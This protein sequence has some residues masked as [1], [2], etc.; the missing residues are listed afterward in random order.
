MNFKFIYEGICKKIIHS[1]LTVIQFTIG[2]MCIF[3]AIQTLNDMNLSISNI[4]SYFKD[5]EYCN[6]KSES[7]AND[8]YSIKVDDAGLVGDIN[9]LIKIKDY[10]ENSKEFDFLHITIDDMPIKRNSVLDGT[11][12]TYD[13]IEYK[14]EEYLRVQA[15]TANKKF[16]KKMNY[17][18]IKG[19]IEDFESLKTEVPVILGNIYKDK[20]N[21]GDTIGA[22][23]LDGI[24]EEAIKLK[25][26]G[27]LDKDN[28]VFESGISVV[29]QTLDNSMI[30]PYNDEII[31][32]LNGAKT[33][34]KGAI[35][36][37]LANY[38]RYGYMVLNENIDIKKINKELDRFKYKFK[39]ESLEKE[40]KEYRKETMDTLSPVIF[41]AILIIAFTMISIVIIMIN[42]I[43]KDKAEYGINIMLGATMKDIKKRVVG[44]VIILL[45]ISCLISLGLLKAIP[46]F[47][48][49][50]ID[51]MITILIM[52]IFM[53]IV[54][55][56]I[57]RYLNKY[58]VTDLIRRQE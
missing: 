13:P 37:S 6:I 49:N 36:I 45:T 50:F 12:L 20:Y 18:F 31:N 24:E 41:T 29:G 58:S 42:S 32:H 54:A 26:I 44:E 53:M 39:I 16:L 8:L 40:I 19:G 56:I 21:I 52:G 46:I 17:S 7:I 47:N 3:V 1:I 23:D 55:T 30:F 5:G 35:K 27:I 4:N 2:L 9:E 10:F 22:L 33:E 51:F 11:V 28:Y 43:I 57:I 14:N 34:E 15:Y 48:F 38:L 25:V